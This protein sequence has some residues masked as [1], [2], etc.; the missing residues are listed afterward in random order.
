VSNEE[1]RREGDE[2]DN[3]NQVR[4]LEMY[5]GGTVIFTSVS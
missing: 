2:E 5:W 4:E 1:G 3:L